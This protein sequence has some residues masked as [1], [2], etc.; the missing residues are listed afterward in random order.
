MS[1]LR[2]ICVPYSGRSGRSRPAT[3][4]GRKRLVIQ[5]EPRL[6]PPE[7]ATPPAYPFGGS[8]HWRMLNAAF[9]R[10]DGHAADFR[11]RPPWSNHE[12]LGQ[13]HPRS[14]GVPLAGSNETSSNQT[15]PAFRLDTRRIST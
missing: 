10:I 15:V 14:A 11:G 4:C 1:D 3:R 5:S 6:A 12:R 13:L 7:W 9:S 2:I 8:H